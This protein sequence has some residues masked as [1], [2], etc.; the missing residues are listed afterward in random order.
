MTVLT[1]RNNMSLPRPVEQQKVTTHLASTHLAPVDDSEMVQV[2]T[3]PGQRLGLALSDAKGKITVIGLSDQGV[4]KTQLSIGDN[5]LE[6]NGTP[7]RDEAM[8]MKLCAN[9]DV[10]VVTFKVIKRELLEGSD[11]GSNASSERT[12]SG[13]T[14][15]QADSSPPSARSATPRTSQPR[16]L[17]RIASFGRRSS[18]GVAL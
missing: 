12:T 11:E 8:G 16:K 15:R 2:F 10:G 13:E 9:A 18:P 17:S 3:A 7:V 14:A 6:V 4:A 1:P 5:I